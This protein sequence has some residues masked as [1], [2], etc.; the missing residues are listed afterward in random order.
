MYSWYPM[1]PQHSTFE[2]VFK[3]AAAL[4]AGNRPVNGS[5]TVSRDA[6]IP[7]AIL[8]RLPHCSASVSRAFPEPKTVLLRKAEAM[9][10]R[11]PNRGFA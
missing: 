10:V 1:R 4:I 3:S 11:S 6:V 9:A 5:G 7:T 8:D 2:R